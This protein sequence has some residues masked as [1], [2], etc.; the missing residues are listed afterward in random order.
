MENLDLIFEI[1]DSKID[2]GVKAN[3]I[4]SLGDL[5]NRFPNILNERTNDI[6]KLLHDDSAKVRRQA[7]MVITHLVLNDMLKLKGQIV[8]ICMLLED[9]DDRIKDQV[10]LFLHELHSKG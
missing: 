3:I 1:L 5:F 8:D 4:I 6:F 10:E 9:P 2:F 7:L